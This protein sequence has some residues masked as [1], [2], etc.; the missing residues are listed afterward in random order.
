[1]I[2]LFAAAVIA[3]EKVLSTRR[4]Y[5]VRGAGQEAARLS[6]QEL[7]A[8]VFWGGA[9]R[10]ELCDGVATVTQLAVRK[11]DLQCVLERLKR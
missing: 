8:G 4:D 11:L 9:M 2:A 1:M 5:G 6:E 7:L 10:F 3:Y